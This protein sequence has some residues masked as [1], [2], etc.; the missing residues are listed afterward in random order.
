M[1]AVN[2]EAG[3]LR[4]AVGIHMHTPDDRIILFLAPEKTAQLARGH[5]ERGFLVLHL[6]PYML[7]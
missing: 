5:L 4:S 7:T 6:H 3:D 1:V 2:G